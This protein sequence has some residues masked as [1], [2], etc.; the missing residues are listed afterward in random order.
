MFRKNI[1]F[2]AIGFA[3]IFALAGPAR[4]PASLT[5]LVVSCSQT[6]GMAGV[7]AS[8]SGT[9]QLKAMPNGA[10]KGTGKLKIQ[11]LNPRAPWSGE[12][13]VIGQY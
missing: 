7:T 3:P 4:V 9:L 10:A 12:V 2:I 6:K 1:L 11:I 5:D 13:S 8:A